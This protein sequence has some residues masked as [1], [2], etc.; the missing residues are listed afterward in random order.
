VV[1][2][3]QVVGILLHECRA[4]GRDHPRILPH[5]GRCRRPSV[6]QEAVL[7]DRGTICRCF[8]HRWQDTSGRSPPGIGSCES[9]T[10]ASFTVSCSSCST[11]PM[12]SPALRS[13]MWEL[14]LEGIRRP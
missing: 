7:R 6:S 1:V 12:P 5:R 8:A 9:S 2:E 4:P 11:S 13:W 14:G 3:A 10:C